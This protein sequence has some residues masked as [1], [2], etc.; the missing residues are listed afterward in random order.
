MNDDGVGGSEV[1]AGVGGVE[2]PPDRG[3]V[4]F[5]VAVEIKRCHCH[6]SSRVNG[7]VVVAEEI[8]VDID[9]LN[10]VDVYTWATALV[11]GNCESVKIISNKFCKLISE[12]TKLTAGA[13][14]NIS[15]FT[16]LALQ[17]LIN[18]LSSATV[19]VNDDAELIGRSGNI[20]RLWSGIERDTH[21]R[22][23]GKGVNVVI[24]D[25]D[26]R[27][28]A[29]LK[30]EAISDGLHVARNTNRSQVG[31]AVDLGLFPDVQ[32]ERGTT[33]ETVGVDAVAV[34]VV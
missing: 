10:V 5:E 23:W 3:A 32:V 28:R 20:P 4:V 17:P 24:A 9:Q 8:T 25:G 16:Q 12:L 11:V 26:L 31:L 30:R 27:V 33:V 29:G 14:I 13:C 21:A 18:L 7:A 1:T 19:G 6:K 2:H 22:V 34:G 15:C